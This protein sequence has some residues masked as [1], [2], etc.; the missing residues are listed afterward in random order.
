MP[1]WPASQTPLFVGGFSRWG[2]GTLMRLTDATATQPVS[3]N[4]TANEALFIPFSIPWPYL[5]NRV[6]W[7][8]GS[9][10]TTSN[11]DF[12]IYT[13]TGKR[14]WS[15]G[16]TALSGASAIQ[17]A[18]VTSPFLLS[19]GTY[20]MAYA[21]DNT[22]NRI[23]GITGVTAAGLLSCTGLNALSSAFP[24]P[25]APALAGYTGIVATIPYM[26]ITRTTAGF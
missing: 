9:T 19:P 1:D 24:L 25:A 6:F 8:N 16:S 7:M 13:S 2:M 5:V 14:I 23:S 26:G 10:I 15:L 20:F 21:G 4:W 18:T 12:G 3:A 11:A 17:Y 22:T